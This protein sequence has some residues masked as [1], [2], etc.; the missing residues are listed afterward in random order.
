MKKSLLIFILL[1]FI[2]IFLFQNHNQLIFINNNSHNTRFLVQ[3]N[4]FKYKSS[5]L[6]S[7]LTD[8]MYKLRNYLVDNSYKYKEYKK[9]ID[10]LEKGFNNNRTT[11]SEKLPKSNYTSY[12]IN[13]GED[14]VFCLK[15][16][17]TNEF[18]DINTLMYV[19]LHEMA[20]I[21]CPEIGHGYLFQKIFKFLTLIAIEL[22]L[23]KYQDYNTDPVEYCGM[24][25][26]SSI[27]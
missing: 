6:L 1:I 13:K 17:I 27:I 25:I 14:L 19:A 20:H 22:N 23:Y 8:K 15:N 16:K 18:H 12:S 10:L 24:T 26:S 5:E 2:Y 4:K 11:I 9:Y 21:G 3:N 7:K